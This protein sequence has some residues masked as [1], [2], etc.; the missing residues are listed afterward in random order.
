VSTDAERVGEGAHRSRR[1]TIRD[2]AEHLGLSVSTVSASLNGGGTLRESTRERVRRAAEELGY[3]PSRAALAF[4]LGRTG[5]IAYSLPAAEEGAPAAREGG[6]VPVLDVEAYM[7]GARAAASAAFEAGYALTLTPPSIHGEAGWNLIGADGVVVCDPV[8]GDERL[9]TLERL[10]TPVVTISRDASRP[11]WPFVVTN[12][13]RGNA[14]LLLDHLHSRGARSIAL[15]V[16][17]ASWSSTVEMTQGY[18]EWISRQGLEEIIWTIPPERVSHDAYVDVKRRLESGPRPDAIF[19]AA[20]Q[21][22]PGVL[23]ACRELEL[24]I[25]EDMLFVLGGDSQAAAHGEPS[26]TAID[27]LSARQSELAVEMLLRRIDGQPVDGPI[28]SESALSVRAS[29]EN[30]VGK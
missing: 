15:L 24:S 2:V 6:S 18:R 5:T 29:T 8:S 1:V 9:S 17:D 22:R 13:Y 10:G 26:I 19:S 4:R 25:P 14:Q 27:L 11:D 28:I 23:R 21:Y 20:E 12:D 30:G 3:R 16:P 7:I